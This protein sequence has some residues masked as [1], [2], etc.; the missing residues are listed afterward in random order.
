MGRGRGVGLRQPGSALASCT[1]R[2]CSTHGTARRRGIPRTRHDDEPDR[3]HP[4][5]RAPDR[6]GVPDRY[7]AKNGYASQQ[8]DEPRSLDRPDNLYEPVPGDHGA[9]GTFDACASRTS[10]A[11]WFDKNRAPL[12]LAVAAG[13]TL[14]AGTFGV[15][16]ARRALAR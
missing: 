9:H 16:W 15:G 11:W 7:L 5:E 12:L 10:T 13:L 2:E 8:T 6:H 4:R 1:P 14:V 3:A